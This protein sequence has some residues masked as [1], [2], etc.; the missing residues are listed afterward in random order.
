MKFI[1]I[2][3]IHMYRRVVKPFYSKTCLYNESCSVHVER[4]TRQKGLWTGLKALHYRFSN[5]RPGYVIFKHDN[6]FQ[7]IT[8]QQNIVKEEDINPVLLNEYS[9]L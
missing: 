9:R 5:C 8:Q 3:F 1:L 4:I 2:F 6:Q 7:M